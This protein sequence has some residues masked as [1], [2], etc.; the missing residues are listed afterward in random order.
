MIPHLCRLAWN[1]RRTNLLLVAEFFLSFLVL[2]PWSP[3]GCCS[4][5]RS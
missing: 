5:R 2:T 4:P 1:R 3:A